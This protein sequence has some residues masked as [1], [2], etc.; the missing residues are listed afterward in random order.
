MVECALL[1]P[2]L[3]TLPG[4]VMEHKTDTRGIWPAG[5]AT[6]AGHDNTDILDPRAHVRSYL[7]IFASSY[8]CGLLVRCSLITAS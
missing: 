6:V 2:W 4:L 5:A 8:G 3:G 1:G 7:F